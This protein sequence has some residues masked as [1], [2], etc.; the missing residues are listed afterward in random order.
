[1]YNAYFLL[2]PMGVVTFTRRSLRHSVAPKWDTLQKPLT[3]IVPLLD[4]TI[5]DDGAGMLQVDFANKLV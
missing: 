5:E 3:K 1:M 2:V 4:G